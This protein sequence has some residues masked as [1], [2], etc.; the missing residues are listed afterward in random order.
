M[1]DRWIP[2]S[3]RSVMVRDSSLTSHTSF[4]RLRR[5]LLLTARRSALV[6]RQQNCT[7]FPRKG[8]YHR[9]PC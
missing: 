4:G 9:E 1:A 7:F 3:D 6:V 2:I 8:E 5:S